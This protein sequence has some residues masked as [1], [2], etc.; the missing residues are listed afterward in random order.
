MPWA[1]IGR[2]SHITFKVVAVLFLLLPWSLRSL[3]TVLLRQSVPL[4]VHKSR[5]TERYYLP[6]C[7][8]PLF[9][10][11]AEMSGITCFKQLNVPNAC[12]LL[13][14]TAARSSSG[15]FAESR[16]F[17]YYDF[18]LLMWQTVMVWGCRECLFLLLYLFLSNALSSW[19]LSG[20][21]D[22]RRCCSAMI[23]SRQRGNCRSTRQRVCSSQ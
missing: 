17:P 16:P 18:T 6:H 5:Q 8:H 20:I 15:S 4:S 23:V 19:G 7:H 22:I 1:V 10:S 21:S 2:S 11:A 13:A 12:K 14:R 3:R 9:V